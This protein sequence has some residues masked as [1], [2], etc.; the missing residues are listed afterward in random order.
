MTL[1]FT[2]LDHGPDPRSHKGIITC[3]ASDNSPVSGHARLGQT[4]ITQESYRLYI[5]QVIRLL[6][7]LGYTSNNAP[8]RS[9]VI[10]RHVPREK[11]CVVWYHIA[12]KFGDFTLFKHLVK[13]SW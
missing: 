11:S 7:K 2:W 3:T 6:R 10:V 12:G 9:K 1:S 5:L 13:E 4:Q 8:E